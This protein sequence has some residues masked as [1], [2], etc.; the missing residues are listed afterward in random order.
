MS[1]LYSGVDE[2]SYVILT[3]QDLSY[4]RYSD[5]HSYND[6]NRGL[7]YKFSLVLGGVEGVEEVSLFFCLPL[8]IL[9]ELR[10]YFAVRPKLVW[11]REA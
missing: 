5:H 3:M 8:I 9:G 4:H 10:G 6:S 11:C 1:K 2:L 7:S